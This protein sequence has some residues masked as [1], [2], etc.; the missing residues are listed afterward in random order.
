MIDD[1]K[2]D[3]KYTFIISICLSFLLIAFSLGTTTNA[4]TIGE[5]NA[6]IDETKAQK[7]QIDAEIKKYQEQIKKT[8]D[9]AKT[10]Q[11]A[12]NQLNLNKK[13]LDNDIKSTQAKIEETSLNIEKLGIQIVSKNEDISNNEKAIAA[14]IK[15]LNG[16]D[17]TPLIE[18]MFIYNNVSDLWNEIDKIQ[19]FEDAVR[20]NI[21]KIKNAKKELEENKKQVEVKKNNLLG[22]KQDLGDQKQVVQENQNEKSS[23]LSETKSNEATYKKL[24]AQQ[25]A[26]SDAF[27]RELMDYESQLQA[28]INP[29]KIP[30]SGKGI[31]QWPLDS[32]TVTQGFGGTD[33]AKTSGIYA[34]NFHPG[35]DFRAAIGTRIMSALGGVVIGTGNTDLACKGASWGKWVMIQHKNGLSTLYAHL[36]VIK[37]TEGQSVSTGEVIAYSGNTGASTGPHLHFS[38]YATEGVKIGTTASKACKGKIYTQPLLTEKGA[39]LDPLSYL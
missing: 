11:S 21:N 31:L 35:V 39:Y 15:K 3:F 33:F 13:K 25:Q 4:A 32:I 8:G 27:N 26:M 37:V 10:L 12:I 22:L 6:K 19:T 38:V 14:S 17:K 34:S 5:L 9:E 28:V 24:L 29:N 36:S 23:L 18:N 16:M 2:K 30:K 1:L 20:D 7:A